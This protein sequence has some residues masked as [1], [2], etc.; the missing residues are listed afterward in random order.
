MS[1]SFE[2]DFSAPL[3]L[4]TLILVRGVLVHACPVAMTLVLVHPPCAQEPYCLCTLV[5]VHPPCAHGPYCTLVLVPYC[6]LVL[7]SA[8]LHSCPR[9]CPTALLSSCTLLVHTGS[10]ACAQGPYCLCTLV[11]VHPCSC[12]SHMACSRHPLLWPQLFLQA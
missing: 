3:F 9:E 2:A 7:V 1:S 6:T 11:H 5:L 10:T 8:L 4:C 12:A